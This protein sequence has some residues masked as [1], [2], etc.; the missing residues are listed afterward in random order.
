MDQRPKC[1]VPRV[2]YAE[3]V[4]IKIPAVRKR[5][6]IDLTTAIKE[7]EGDR[8]YR[9]SILQRNSQEGLVKVRYVGYGR[10]FD[11]GIPKVLCT[12]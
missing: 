9:L 2:N 7:S 8:L 12:F 1:F 6:A 11:D 4:D 10:E 5:K 3:L